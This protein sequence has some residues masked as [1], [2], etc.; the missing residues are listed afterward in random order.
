M[1]DFIFSVQPENDLKPK[2]LTI[3][4]VERAFLHIFPVAKCD[5]N[6]DIIGMYH[7]NHTE[8]ASISSAAPVSIQD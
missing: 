1:I 3:E 4:S 8:L 5:N 7:Q 2:K 6:C